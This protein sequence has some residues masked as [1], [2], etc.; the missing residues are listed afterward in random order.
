MSTSVRLNTDLRQVNCGHTFC[1]HCITVWR[2]KKPSCPVCRADIKQLAACK[3][4]CILIF[5]HLVTKCD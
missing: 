1:H 2:A 4:G 3:V 5:S